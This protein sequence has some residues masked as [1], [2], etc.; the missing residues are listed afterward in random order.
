MKALVT[1]A[2]GVIGRA[3]SIRLAEQSF[4]VVLS[5]RDAA[6]AEHV[7]TEIRSSGAR[8]EA[9]GADITSPS[10]VKA[11]FAAAGEVHVLIHAAAA[12]IN[13]KR[14]KNAN[15]SDY[16]HH[17]NVAVKGAF[18]LASEWLRT[19]GE[20]HSLS[21]VLS[22]VTVGAIAPGQSAYAAGK[23]GLLGFAKALSAE[24]AA[25][26]ISVN[27]VSPG[28]VGEGLTGGV[29]DRVREVIIKATPMGR[30]AAPRDIAEVVSFLASRE[31]RYLTGLNI[32]IA[33]GLGS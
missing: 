2:G 33:G 18:L 24:L 20:R 25:K 32:P 6:K 8:V 21:F 13:E 7:A 30:L 19:K 28:F 4:E 14:V 3:I 16:E 12:P 29:D 1:G 9:F 22:S 10:D 15:W 23:F 26:Q 27:C 11:L 5:D 17:L 31:A